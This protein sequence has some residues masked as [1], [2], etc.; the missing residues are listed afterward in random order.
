MDVQ[1]L[2]VWFEESIDTY[3]GFQRCLNLLESENMTIGVDVLT[4]YSIYC[5]CF[6][7]TFEHVRMSLPT[8]CSYCRTRHHNSLPARVGRDLIATQD[9][10]WPS[11]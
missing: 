8:V 6:A 4:W 7:W 9:V 5:M 1:S 3:I 10:S 2:R 11:T